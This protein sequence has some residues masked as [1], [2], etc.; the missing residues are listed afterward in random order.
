MRTFRL[1]LFAALF[2][3]LLSPLAQAQQP[4]TY[5]INKDLR[6]LTISAT[7]HAESDPDVADLHIGFTAYGPTLKAAYKSASDTSN[8][9]LQ[10]MLDAGATHTDIQS[11]SQRVSRLFDWEIKSQHGQK[12]SV[13]QSWT[14]STAPDAAAL[15]LDAAIQAG[16]NDSGNITWRMKTSIPLESEAV[17]RATTR[18]QTLATELAKSLGATLG[19][20]LYASNTMKGEVAYVNGYSAN[21]MASLEVD[22]AKFTAPAPLAIEAQRVER[23]ATVNIIFA[24]E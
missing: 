22:K 5:Q 21:T 11:K 9:I 17:H 3:P 19:K 4:P 2:A 15:I 10:T 1:S 23:T 12:Y 24:L 13:H 7:D 8:A 20:P 16:A 6:T 18:A 14:V